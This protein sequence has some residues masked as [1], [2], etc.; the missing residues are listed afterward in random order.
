M[1]LDLASLKSVNSF[2]DEFKKRNLDLSVLVCNAGV[3][4]PPK[5]LET[6]D[7]LERQFQVWF[8]HLNVVK[9]LGEMHIYCGYL[10]QLAVE[11][12]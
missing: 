10:P 8:S 4:R 6:E 1:P 11:D 3:M 9:P 5:R 2:C 7:G 12:L